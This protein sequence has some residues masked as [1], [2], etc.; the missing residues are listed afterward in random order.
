MLFACFVRKR[1]V[2]AALPE[3]LHISLRVLSWAKTTAGVQLCAAVNKKDDDRRAALL[4]TQKRIGAVFRAKEQ[5]IAE[6]KR[7]QQIID[8]LVTSPTKESVESPAKSGT[9]EMDARI[10][11]FFYENGIAFNVADSTSFISMID[12]SIKFRQTKPSSKL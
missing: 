2:A 8:D 9:K 6:Q 5:Y 1:S 4:K 7:R 10:A 11:S 3:Q 12:E